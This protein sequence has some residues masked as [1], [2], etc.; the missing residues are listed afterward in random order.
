MTDLKQV[1]ET[2]KEIN[3]ALKTV[4]DQIKANAEK[5]HKDGELNAET[6]AKVD[7][8]LL[9]QGE[10]QARLHETEQKLIGANLHREPEAAPKSAGQQVIEHESLQNRNSGSRF[11]ARVSM[12][13][14]AITSI[15]DGGARVTPS[16][17]LD[18]IVGGTF[19]RMTLRDLLAPGSTGAAA[20]EYV[21]ESG[22]TNEIGRAHV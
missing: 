21:R 1:E 7:E 15:G 20:M 12:P 22:F 5:A 13:R 2:Q 6:R 18:Q 19:R 4:G 11:T 17:R 8:L 16:E 3:A 14:A 10:L 9:K